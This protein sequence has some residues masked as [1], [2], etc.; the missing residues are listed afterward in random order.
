MTTTEVTGPV[1]WDAVPGA[2]R[3][4]GF[5]EASAVLRGD[6]WSSDLRLSPLVSEE[7]KDMPGGNMLISDP[8]EHTRLRRL[9][10]PA[11]TPKAIELLRPRVASIV[12]SVL[13]G[14]DEIG[15]QIDVLADVG[16]PV[17][18]AVMTELLDVGVEGAELFAEHTPQLVRGFEFDADLADLRAMAGA[19]TELTMFLTAVLTD[20]RRS[21]GEDFISALLALSGDDPDGLNLGEV[22]ATCI[23]LLVA[24]HETTANLIATSTLTLLDNPG[25]VAQLLADPGRAA[26]EMLRLH[27]PAKQTARTALIDHNLADHHIATGQAVLVDI[28]AANRDP[29]RFPDPLRLDLT[30][31]PNGHLAFGAGA[32]FCLGAALARLELVETLTRMFTRYP[33]LALTGSPIRWRESTALHGLHALPARIGP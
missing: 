16:Y 30:R 19:T 6:G 23:L 14:L 11:F 25:A 10:S 31:D 33:N 22:M 15:P 24:G 9:V 28:Q 1:R 29:L 20:R 27:G 26:E 18:L 8:P 3:V 7:L 2:F 21:P 12:D 13:D 5:A 32:H 4:S 17:T